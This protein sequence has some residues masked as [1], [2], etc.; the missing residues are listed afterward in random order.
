MRT[1][2]RKHGLAVIPKMYTIA[3][4]VSYGIFHP[5][6]CQ[7][8]EFHH[9]TF[10]AVQEQLPKYVVVWLDVYLASFNV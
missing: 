3:G 2:K 5:H 10:Y 9:K 6:L 4:G 1:N 7:I 8:F